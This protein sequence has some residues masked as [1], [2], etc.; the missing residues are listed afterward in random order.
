MPIFIIFYGQYV[1]SYNSLKYELLCIN[2]NKCYIRVTCI[3][4]LGFRLIILD[5]DFFGVISM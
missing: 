3:L 2:E 5:N 1:M 4:L